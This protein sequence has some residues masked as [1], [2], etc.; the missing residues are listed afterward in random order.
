MLNKLLRLR[1]LKEPA[2]S[3]ILDGGLLLDGGDGRVDGRVSATTAERLGDA[4][5]DAEAKTSSAR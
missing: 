4:A 1:L 2:R 5:S 3:L